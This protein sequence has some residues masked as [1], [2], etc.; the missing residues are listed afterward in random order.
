METSLQFR[1]SR[2]K[3]VGL[4][5][6]CSGFVVLALLLEHSALAWVTEVFFGLGALVALAS[7]MP[8]S[9]FLRIEP[10]RLL[11]RT[12]YRTWSLE[13]TQVAEF[14]TA[15]VGGREVVCWSY[16]PEY[17]RQLRGRA[18]ARAISGV[19]AALPDTYGLPAAELAAVLNEWRIGSP[20]S[21]PNNSSKP[22]PL[23]GAA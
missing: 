2:W 1:P 19:E 4:L 12:L 8:G 11:V 17:K 18:F 15:P 3:H 23:R 7:L 20:D 6:I 13:R 9:S 14:Y 21:R 22:T 5:A 10:D 16:V